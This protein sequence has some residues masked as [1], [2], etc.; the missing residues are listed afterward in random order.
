M[1]RRLLFIIKLLLKVK[2][3]F[4]SPQRHEVVIFDGEIGTLKDLENLI[5]NYNF[6]ILQNRIENINKVHLSFQVIKYFFKH[7]NGNIMTAYLVSLLEIIRPK[8]VLTYVDN[9]LKFFDIAKILN[10]KICFIAIQNGARYD[11]KIHKHFYETKKFNSDL[12]KNFFIPNFMCYG[13]IEID[14][15]KKDKI[16]VKNFFKVGSLRHAN[17]FDYL[18]KNKILLQK[19]LYDICL[20]SD[21]MYIGTND[22]FGLPSIEKGFADTIKYTIQFCIKHKMKMI[23]AWKRDKK[24]TPEAFRLEI[25]FYKKYLTDNEF[26]YLVNNSLEKDRF[27]SYKAMFQSKVVV[28]TYSTLLR[29]NLGVGGKILSCNCTSSNIFDFPIEGICSIKNC[30]F[31]EF[32]KRLLDIHSISKE[33]YFSKL[34]KDKG[35]TMEYDEKISTIEILRKKINL[36][37]TNEPL[38]KKL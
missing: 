23:F 19:S 24:E 16:E 14:D 9:S 6:F 31:Q 7:Y 26:N 20:I 21:P 27:A 30:N 25:E 5:S 33:N 37:L 18:N 8:V 32:E 28:A 3:I 29:E 22:K 36:L 12:R 13:Q 10:K 34:T 38:S 1:K 15:Y 4:K 17:F 35:Y 11:L 2:F